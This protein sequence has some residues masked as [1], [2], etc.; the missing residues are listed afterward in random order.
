MIT[1]LNIFRDIF[2][3]AHEDYTNHKLYLVQYFSQSWKQL[4]TPYLK[5]RVSFTLFTI[6]NQV[7]I[8]TF[9]QSIVELFHVQEHDGMYTKLQ[10]IQDFPLSIPIGTHSIISV[11]FYK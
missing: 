3:L 4:D 5:S 11:P 6:R 10:E 7:F 2:L 9:Q 8:M 1:F